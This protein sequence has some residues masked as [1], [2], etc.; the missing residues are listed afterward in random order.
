VAPDRNRILEGSERQLTRCG[1]RTGHRGLGHD[2]CCEDVPNWRKRQLQGRRLLEASFDQEG[3]VGWRGELGPVLAAW[4][5]VFLAS[6]LDRCEIC[7]LS[8]TLAA[9]AD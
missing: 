2:L 1:G 4:G 5:V 8:V 6:G 3:Y 9:S 7:R